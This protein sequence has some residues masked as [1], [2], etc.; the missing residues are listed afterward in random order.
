MPCVHRYS[1]SPY[2]L[3]KVSVTFPLVSPCFPCVFE[4]KAAL[5]FNMLLALKNG[6]SDL[7]PSYF[8]AM[9]AY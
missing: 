3:H 7:P 8:S 4:W 2:Q 9:I 1:K 5:F 6:N